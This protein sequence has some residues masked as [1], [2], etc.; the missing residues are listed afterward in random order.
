MS[1]RDWKRD[2]EHSLAAS[3]ADA[4]CPGFGGPEQREHPRLLAAGLTLSLGLPVPLRLI[5]AGPERIEFYA[6]APLPPGQRIALRH[7][8]A[9]ASE[10][11]VVG[12]LLEPTDPDLLELRYRIRCRPLLIPC[13]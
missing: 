6:E 10:V 3:P 12:C 4:G 2:Y 9:P 5:E 7:G 1:G 8:E 11:E 13:D